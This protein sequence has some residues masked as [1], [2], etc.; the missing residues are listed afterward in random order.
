MPSPVANTIIDLVPTLDEEDRAAISEAIGSVRV[1]TDTIGDIVAIIDRLEAPPLST[2]SQA[3]YHRQSELAKVQQ[4]TALAP[5]SAAAG[6]TPSI[7]A[8]YI[9]RASGQSG[10][11]IGTV[12]RLK[13]GAIG[14]VTYGRRYN[15]KTP[16]LVFA[17][18][19]QV[20]VQ[21]SKI[22]MRLYSPTPQP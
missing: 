6:F 21:P 20:S 3:V 14:V 13:D 7:S 15:Q 17:S 18:G 8:Q 16:T 5:I 9:G 12:V 19:Q 22:A 10:Y 2:L 11:T 4:Q 1:S